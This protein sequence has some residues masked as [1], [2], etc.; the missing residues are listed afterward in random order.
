VSSPGKKDGAEEPFL[1]LATERQIHA[2]DLSQT[3]RVAIGRHESNDLQLSSRTVSNYHAE[4]LNE[5]EGLV[6]HDLRSTNGTFVNEK[7]ISRHVLAPAD[8]IRIGNFVLTVHRQPRRSPSDTL[9]RLSEASSFGVGTRGNLISLRA[10]SPEAQKTLRSQDPRDLSLPDL[11]K[12]LCTNRRALVVVARRQADEARIVVREGSILDAEYGPAKG[13]K[14]LYRLFAW[15]R[16]T[17]E[18]V[19][20]PRSSVP[21]T[22]NLPTDAVILEGMKEVEELDRLRKILPPFDQ[23]LQ[24][25]ENCTLPLCALSPAEIE[26]FQ[27]LIRHETI[28][29]AVEN[30][31][32]T[33]SRVVGLVN[34]LLQKGVFEIS[35][36]ATPS[37]LEATILR[38][39][40]R[41]SPR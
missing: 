6:L 13:E 30:S 2:F 36:S 4:I 39:P 18:L 40:E 33:D 34:A 9:Y 17:Y 19:E 24:L 32:L 5:S 12:F 15:E 27:G 31:A 28:E 21:R 3:F 38:R 35:D 41:S 25:K 29:R 11:L 37:L 20:F 26:V 23:K 14:A 10:G 22:I 1:L 16:A 7:P 8:R